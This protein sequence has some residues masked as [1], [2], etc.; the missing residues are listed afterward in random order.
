ME[1]SYGVY[2][3][4]TDLIV[5]V[6]EGMGDTKG[7][8]RVVSILMGHNGCGMGGGGP[9]SSKREVKA[10]LICVEGNLIMHLQCERA[11]VRVG[12]AACAQS[13]VYTKIN[14]FASGLV[15]HHHVHFNPTHK[16]LNY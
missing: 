9:R 14:I 12:S 15:C 3:Y 8:V 1:A 4:T 2:Q 10:S 11:Q 7:E 6:G 13:L 5:P 16:P